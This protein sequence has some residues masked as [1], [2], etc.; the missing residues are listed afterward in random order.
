[1][2]GLVALCHFCELHGPS[3][4]MITQSVKDA[5]FQRLED[6][7]GASRHSRLYGCQRLFSEELGGGGEVGVATGCE[8]CSSLAQDKFLVSSDP[9][10]RR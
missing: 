2:P 1:M 8:G 4:I 7:G 9:C 3:V 10:G 5:T 6:G